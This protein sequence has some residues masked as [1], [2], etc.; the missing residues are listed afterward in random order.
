M[1]IIVDEMPLYWSDCPFCNTLHCKSSVDSRYSICEDEDGFI[2]ADYCPYLMTIDEYIKG[3]IIKL[4]KECLVQDIQ[5]NN[6]Y[7]ASSNKIERIG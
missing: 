7:I 2:D 1:R 4:D 5:T 6:L 3:K